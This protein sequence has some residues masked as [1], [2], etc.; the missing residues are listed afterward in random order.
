MFRIE[1]LEHSPVSPEILRT[2]DGLITKYHPAELRRPMA[3]LVERIEGRT[4][5][6]AG[7]GR[8]SSGK[9][10]LLNAIL[11]EAQRS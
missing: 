3:T 2:L 9:S 6:V 11:G 10:S 8:V 4:F 5:N 1:R 7:F